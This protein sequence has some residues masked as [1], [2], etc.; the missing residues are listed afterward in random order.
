MAYCVKCGV[1]LAATEKT[2]PLCNTR[3]ILPE[4]MQKEERVTEII[5]IFPYRNDKNTPHPNKKH[6]LE[7]ITL[8]FFLPIPVLLL[9]DINISDGIVWSGYAVGGIVLLYVYLVFPFLPKRANGILSVGADWLATLFYLLYVNYAVGGS[10]F[11]PFALP[12]VSFMMF[13]VMVI[14]L[15]RRY[16]KITNLSLTGISLLFT[17]MFCLVTEFLINYVFKVH[18]TLYWSFYPAL[19][20]AMCAIVVF[21]IDR[22]ATLKEKLIRKLTI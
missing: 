22:N 18:E 4:E 8:I 9:C 17:G 16:T 7:L 11:M 2:C 14:V 15:F 1:E 20:L 5:P 21:Y 6:F 12:L 19:S 10:W 3:V 13:F